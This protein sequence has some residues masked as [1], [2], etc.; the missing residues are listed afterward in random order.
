MH[1]LKNLVLAAFMSLLLVSL[2]SSQDPQKRNSLLSKRAGNRNA[3][4]KSTTTTT[5]ASYDEEEYVEGAELAPENEQ[6]P[7]ED[8][9][10]ST[11]TSTTESPKK[12][13]PSVRPFR[14][15]EEL[16]SAL[17]KRRLNEKSQKSSV[18]PKPVQEEKPQYEP[19]EKPTKPAKPAAPSLPSGN[20]RFGGH[21][22][23]NV[24][25]PVQDNQA[26]T[27]D[28]PTSKPFKRSNRFT[29]NRQSN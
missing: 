26:Q 7:S 27:I 5:E 22:S 15:N 9:A 2:S 16:L 23:T 29:L 21:K 13:G 8:E 28:E 1:L 3:F 6:Q 17:K 4:Q 19:E 20:R 11:T 12:V 24:K 25:A 14:S 10:G 18:V